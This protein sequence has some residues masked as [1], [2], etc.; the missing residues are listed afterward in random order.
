MRRQADRAKNICYEYV[1]MHT[2]KLFI[3]IKLCSRRA[4]M[5]AADR[6]YGPSRLTAAQSFREF[7]QYAGILKTF[8]Q[9]GARPIG[10]LAGPPPR[11]IQA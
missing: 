11:G 5:I 1:S 10:E 7:R 8:A 9:R 3:D 2:S 6:A 4:L